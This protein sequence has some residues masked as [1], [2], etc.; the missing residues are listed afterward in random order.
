MTNQSNAVF[1]SNENIFCQIKLEGHLDGQWTAWLEGLTITL[2]DN[3]CT[4]LT[5]ELADQAALYGVLRKVRDV[6]LPLVSVNCVKV[7]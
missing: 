6:G 1:P 4:L 2:G 7:N 3:G 5:G